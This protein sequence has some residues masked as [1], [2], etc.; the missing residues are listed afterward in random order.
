[1]A[2][3]LWLSSWANT[4]AKKHITITT[5]TSHRCA[6]GQPNL[7][8]PNSLA[9]TMVNRMKTISQLAFMST[10]IPKILPSGKESPIKFRRFQILL[11]IMR[12]A[13]PVGL[14]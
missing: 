12:Q 10:G 9:N 5:A 1:L 4:D 2:N 8:W 3:T 14:L 6:I 11:A 7:A 13:V